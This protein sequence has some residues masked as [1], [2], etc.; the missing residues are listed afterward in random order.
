[1]ITSFGRSFGRSFWRQSVIPPCLSMSCR[2]VVSRAV[3]LIVMFYL[4]QVRAVQRATFTHVVAPLATIHE[5][6]PVGIVHNRACAAPRSC[7]VAA[8]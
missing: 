7:L 3:F 8:G 4:T 6:L 5:A 1:M 2:T